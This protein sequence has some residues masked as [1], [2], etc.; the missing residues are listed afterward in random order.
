MPK[1]KLPPR[2]IWPLIGRRSACTRPFGNGP[3]SCATVLSAVDPPGPGPKRI[4]VSASRVP[5]DGVG[6]DVRD[7]AH[8][9]AGAR[10]A[11]ADSRRRQSAAGH[12]DI[13]VDPEAARRPIIS[14]AAAA[15]RPARARRAGRRCRRLVIRAA[16]P[17]GKFTTRICRPTL[18]LRAV[19]P[20]ALPMLAATG[21]IG[22]LAAAASGCVTPAS[23]D[24]SS[25]AL[26]AAK[27]PTM[28]NVP[29]ADAELIAAVEPRA[30]GVDC[31]IRD[32]CADS[33]TRP[34]PS[35]SGPL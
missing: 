14:H 26:S 15:R 20:I 5:F 31:P 1:A 27:S 28:A 33:F 29:V 35:S 12:F 8:R 24:G 16:P 7:A 30:V 32:R 6:R 17:P 25:A 2:P 3:S 23:I 34:R 11:K 19:R 9:R 21:P 22:V 4:G 10:L 18:K 13:A